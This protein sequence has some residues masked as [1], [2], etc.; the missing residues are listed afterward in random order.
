MPLPRHVAGGELIDSPWGNDVVDSLPP[1]GTIDMF[2]GDVA[3]VNWLLCRGQAVSRSTYSVLFA[4]VGTRFGAGDGVTTFNVPNFCGRYP[5]GYNAIAGADYFTLGV[6]EVF[7]S[8]DASTVYHQHAVVLQTSVEDAVHVHYGTTEIEGQAHNHI[9]PGGLHLGS[10]ITADNVGLVGDGYP[11]LATTG[12]EQQNHNHAFVTAGQ[13][14]NHHHWVN[15]A[16]DFTGIGGA[17]A[18]LPPSLSVNYLI[19][20]T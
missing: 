2:A 3:P 5:I 4:L 14:A 6:G 9:I 10:G 11:G 8:K 7:G 20:V 13:N 17:N 12:P 16:S 15:G 18:N 19:R 1:I